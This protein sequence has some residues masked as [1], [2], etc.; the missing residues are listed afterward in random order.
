MRAP[1]VLAVAAALLVVG[2]SSAG[3][4]ATTVADVRASAAGPGSAAVTWQAPG[5]SRAWIEVGRSAPFGVWYPATLRPDGRFAAALTALAPATTYS[6]RIRAA[7]RGSQAEAVGSVTT[8]PISFRSRATTSAGRFVVDGQRL[9]PIMAWWQCPSA[10]DRLLE[11]G[12]N[13]LMGGCKTQ[14]GPDFLRSLGGRAYATLPVADAAEGIDGRGL[15]GWN[16]PDEPEGYGIPASALPDLTPAA[17]SG[18]LRL[19]TS[20]YHFYRGA[21]PLAPGRGH[22]IYA[23]YWAKADVIGFDLYPLE[24][25][26]S[27]RLTLRNDYDIQRQLTQEVPGKPTYQWIE[28]GPLEGECFWSPFR[29]TPAT[30]RAEAWMAIAGGAAGIGYFTHTWTGPGPDPIW[31][32]FEVGLDVQEEIARTNLQIGNL[33]PALTGPDVGVRLVRPS[34]VVVGGRTFNGALYVIAVN[35][36]YSPASA[37][38]RVKGRGSQVFTVFDEG[39]TVQARRGF[40]ADQFAPLA[41]HVYIAAPR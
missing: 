38:I 12:V 21:A 20:T 32:P 37:T 33:A 41:V 7:G 34:P 22:E 24:K 31:R 1:R 8:S 4:S 3:A 26:C 2:T 6:F 17:S 27:H 30:V 16:Y 25:L 29:V 28:T 15:L 40:L 9:F 5:A 36:T 35:P 14:Y 18:R 11:L 19:I 13:L 10:F 23:P 39:R